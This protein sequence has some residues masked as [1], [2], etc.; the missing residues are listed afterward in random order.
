MSHRHL[1]ALVVLAA[2]GT[3][4]GQAD[5]NVITSVGL[6]DEG[7]TVV[8]EITGTKPPNFTTFSMADPPRFVIDLSEARFK[9]VPEDMTVNDGT[10]LVVKSLSYGSDATSIARVMVAFVTDVEPPD[11]RAT[12]ETLAV[13]IVRPTG[14]T[15]VARADDPAQRARAGAEAQA[16]ADAERRAEAEA[17]A[18]ARAEVEAEAR[19]RTG[20]AAG[21]GV[22]AEAKARAEAEAEAKARAE[23]EAEATAQ[24]AAKAGARP[25]QEALRE[26]AAD[27]ARGEA[28]ARAAAG[29]LASTEAELRRLEAAERSQAER[30]AREEAR[31]AKEAEKQRR[32]E[33]ARAAKEAERQRREEARLAR[34][35][36]KRQQAEEARAAKEAEKQRRE[37]ERQ[38]RI[39]AREEAKRAREAEARLAAGSPSAQL[40]EVGF[41]QMPGVSRVFVRTSLTPQFTIQDVG[42]DT[43]R[44]ELQNTRVTRRND[45]RF[46]DTSFFPTAVAMITPSRRGSSYVVDIKL[47]QKVPYQQK[48]E[49]DMLAIDFERP[50]S[51]AAPPAA[52]EAPPGGQEEPAAEA[53]EAAPA[54]AAPAPA[55]PRN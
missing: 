25:A 20:V 21:A 12:G 8:L 45:T 53:P 1:L 42:D 30:R 27:A 55:G 33:E 19:A 29:A 34:E 4:R 31:L 18:K 44:V 47:K 15:A 5:L 2:A 50:G 51:P 9:G 28:G 49:G 10:I 43:V 26:G 48:M 23:V 24:A 22:E 6:R 7:A 39:A 17:E 54:E 46:M 11:V 41:R 13:R 14:G 52:P 3:A 38:A 40:R 37:E 35:E 32:I 16:R 36:A